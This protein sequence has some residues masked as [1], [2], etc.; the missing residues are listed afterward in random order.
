MMS[1]RVANRRMRHVHVKHHIVHDAVKEGVV[2]INYIELE[3]A[4]R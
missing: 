1:Y 2:F 3:T 4:T